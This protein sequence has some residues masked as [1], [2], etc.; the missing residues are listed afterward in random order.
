MAKKQY[1]D[2]EPGQWVHD[3]QG[4]FHILSNTGDRVYFDW[5]DHSGGLVSRNTSL[6]VAT[7][8]KHEDS[9]G[10]RLATEPERELCLRR[11][12][13]SEEQTLGR[14]LKEAAFGIAGEGGEPD[15]DDLV[16]HLEERGDP[17]AAVVLE[18]GHRLEEAR[19]AYRQARNKA[20]S[21]LLGIAPEALAQ[22]VGLG[23]ELF[24]RPHAQEGRATEG[25]QDA[26]E[27]PEGRR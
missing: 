15:L 21:D 26:Q 4:I 2:L 6:T 8:R 17:R 1:F 25:Q 24:S 22:E 3:Y 27:S 11:G 16:G 14:L 5:Y 12:A 10:I 23:V 9:Y 18:I 20:F 19:A 13:A 7:M